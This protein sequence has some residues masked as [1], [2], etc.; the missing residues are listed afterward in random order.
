[1]EKIHKAKENMDGLE[2]KQRGTKK[3][4]RERVSRKAMRYNLEPI[5]STGSTQETAPA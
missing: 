5:I 1:M 4:N 3:E 2:T